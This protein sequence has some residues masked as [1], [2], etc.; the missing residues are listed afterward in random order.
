MA[1]CLFTGRDM[2]IE[3]ANKT[4]I[5]YWGKGEGVLGK[6]LR[7]ALPELAGQPFPQI[8]D[9]VFTTGK[10]YEA[11]EAK[12]DLVVNGAMGRYYFDFTYKALRD[13]DGT[14][15]GVMETAVDATERVL[16]RRKIEAAEERARLDVES[17]DLGTYEVNLH[18]DA[19]TYSPRFCTIWGVEPGATR[20][21]LVATIHPDDL[22]VRQEAHARSLQ[23][24]RIDYETRLI[25]QDES[26]H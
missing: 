12:V 24:G 8:L 22:N 6:P 11:D 2:V 17:A 20:A 5:G 13:A 1:S 10:T 23:I 16:S 9:D 21:H 18:T 4:M 14:I 26:V 15:Y 3:I 19:I 25:R 7:E